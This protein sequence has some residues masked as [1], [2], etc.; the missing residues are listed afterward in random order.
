MPADSAFADS[1][2]VEQGFAYPDW[3]GIARHIESTLPESGWGAAW[4][5][6]AH[7]WLE[8]LRQHLGEAY[9]VH[10]TSNFL[11]LTSAPGHIAEDAK[12]SAEAS[13]SQILRHLD[14]S[15]SDL[16]YGKH[17]VL[18]FA[19]S[20]D[21]Y[22]YVAHFHPDGDVPMSGGLCIQS[23]YTHY[24]FPTYDHNGYRTVL[25]HELTHACLSHLPIPAWLNEALA[26]RME[27]AVTGDSIF[28]L[29]REIFERHLHHWNEET[30]QQFWSGA[31][32]Q[33][34]GDSFELSY[35]LAEILWRK[36]EVDLNASKDQVTS[37]INAATYE[38]GGESAFR[39]TFALG[40]EELAADFLGDGPWA[41]RPERF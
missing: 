28:Y 18:M 8:H 1:L 16:G 23:G 17:V 25:A 27:T 34:P 2:V 19:E 26:M 10:E 41:P 24:A 14:G 9:Q 4:E 38:D 31:A 7:Q 6:V 13:L 37:F 11:I 5:K 36:I 33:I 22:Q 39:A 3:D 30:I 21:Y 29:D 15:A 32:W 20:G 40:L 12:Q 35:N